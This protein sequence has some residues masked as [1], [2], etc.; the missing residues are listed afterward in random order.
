MITVLVM[1][2][3]RRECVEP[4][5][6]SAVRRL[7]GPITR[8]VIHDDSSDD[9]YLA[10]LD[11]LVEAVLLGDE[12]YAREWDVTMLSSPA[13]SGFGGAI[14]RAWAYI[15][16]TRDPGDR[17][18]FHLEDDFTMRFPVPLG[19]KAAVLDAHP[20]VVQLSLQRQPWNAREREAGSVVALHRHAYTV[21]KTALTDGQEC[22]WLRHRR[23]F[24]T[25]PSLYRC[26]LLAGGWPEG[27]HS[28][29]RFGIRLFS[30]PAVSCGVWGEG[31]EWVTHIGA[32]RAGSGY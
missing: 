5:L 25:N 4:T 7:E 11:D 20:D 28:E 13:R 30:D 8:W 9:A 1:T 22:R 15:D 14:R 26:S 27:E 29:G 19:D 3:G 21:E 24:T 17:F 32:H 18:V 12:G 23:V 31:E 10:W 6:R 16:A 2:D